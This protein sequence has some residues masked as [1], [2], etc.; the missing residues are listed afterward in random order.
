MFVLYTTGLKN[1]IIMAPKQRQRQSTNK[2]MTLP[3]L[4]SSQQALAIMRTGISLLQFPFLKEETGF[5][6]LRIKVIKWNVLL[7]SNTTRVKAAAL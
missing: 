7:V 1:P 4:L 2:R 3:K 5:H 6:P